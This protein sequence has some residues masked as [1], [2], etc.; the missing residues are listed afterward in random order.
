MQ[1]FLCCLQLTKHSSNKCLNLN[2]KGPCQVLAGMIETDDQ[3]SIVNKDLFKVQKSHKNFSS[4][5]KPGKNP[6]E[7]FDL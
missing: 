4:L 5:I 1:P 7:V 3:C 2:A 6:S